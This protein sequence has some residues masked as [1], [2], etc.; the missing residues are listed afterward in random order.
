M[1]LW[2]R[3]L[4]ERCHLRLY[5]LVLQQIQTTYQ[6]KIRSYG[7][8]IKQCEVN[9][10]LNDYK[11]NTLFVVLS[12]NVEQFAS[13]PHRSKFVW[14]YTI[15]F[16]QKVGKF[17]ND[18]RWVSLDR[19]YHLNK[20]AWLYEESRMSLMK[21]ETQE[22]LRSLPSNIR[23]E[24]WARHVLSPSVLTFQC[25]HNLPFWASFWHLEVPGNSNTSG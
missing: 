10:R 25:L 17:W 4:E 8:E 7:V 19:K 22:Y 12:L 15:A 1:L 18:I 2:H 21:S 6:R 16:L 5:S 24:P 9:A 13:Q 11:N 20:L 23:W 3:Y 14:T